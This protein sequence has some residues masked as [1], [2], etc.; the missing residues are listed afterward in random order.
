MENENFVLKIEIIRE[1]FNDTREI[2]CITPKDER[3]LDDDV[4]PGGTIFTTEDGEYI[5]L[6]TLIQ[7]FDEEELVKYIDFAENLYEKHGKPVSVYLI[8]PDDIKILVKE[9]TIPS[10]AEFTI[11]IACDEDYP[12]KLALNKIKSKISDGETLNMDDFT[13]LEMLPLTCKRKNR[14]Y[15]RLECLKILNR[16]HY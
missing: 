1:A 8:C 14:K 4:H 5:N 16:L 11:R 12:S 3:Q 10:D 9:I 6:E 7:D 15:F 13:M 2:K